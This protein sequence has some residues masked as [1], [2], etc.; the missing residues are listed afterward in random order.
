MNRLTF[1]T[2]TVVFALLFGEAFAHVSL[3]SK[4][5]QTGASFD[6]TFRVGHGCAGSPTVKLNIR[7]PEGVVA[8]EPQDKDGWSVTSTSG[9]LDHATVSGG[10]SFS[11]GAKVVTWSGR[12]SPHQVATFTLKARLADD[13][14]AGQRVIFPVYQQCEKGEERWIDPN[15]EDD[16]PAPFL[17]IVPKR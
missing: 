4:T 3:E 7:I 1:C 14:V 9:T 15:D 11:E 13:A 16:H 8:V 10:Q 12:L 2:A 17:E 6:A 5:V